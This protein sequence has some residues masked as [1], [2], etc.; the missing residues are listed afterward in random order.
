MKAV[1]SQEGRLDSGTL[2]TH[3]TTAEWVKGFDER[4]RE[5]EEKCASGEALQQ[6][7]THHT[8]VR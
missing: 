5:I 3:L 4:L 7:E 2:L 8:T 1:G 6:E